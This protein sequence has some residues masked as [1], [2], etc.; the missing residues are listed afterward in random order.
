MSIWHRRST[1]SGGDAPN[2]GAVDVPPNPIPRV[3]PLPAPPV[4][5]V[6]VL[7]AVRVE[8][9][10]RPRRWVPLRPILSGTAFRIVSPGGVPLLRP[11]VADALE[12]VFERFAQARGYGSARPLSIEIARGLEPGSAGHY[13]GRA[14]DISAVGGVGFLDWAE[15]W[16]E[17]MREARGHPDPSSRKRVLEAERRRNVGFALYEALRQQGGWRVNPGGWRPYRRVAQLFGPW[18]PTHGPWT[19]IRS[20]EPDAADRQRVADQEWVFHAH[21]DHIHVAR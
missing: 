17:A 5:T 1:E 3:E 15:R 11:D 13:E 16:R 9:I 19:R 21:R 8:A 6:G 2:P 20:D 18:T 4:R 7:T 12:A 10:P 14:A